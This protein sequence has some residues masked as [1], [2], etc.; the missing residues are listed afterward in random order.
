MMARAVAGIDFPL[1]SDGLTCYHVEIRG[2]LQ[3]SRRIAILLATFLVKVTGVQACK[4]TL[5]AFFQERIRLMSLI[6]TSIQ[7]KQAAIV[8]RLP[9]LVLLLICALG[10]ESGFLVNQFRP[11]EPPY[12]FLFFYLLGFIPYL[13]AC[14]L[15]LRTQAS[16]GRM[17][18]L[19]LGVILGGGLVLRWVLLGVEPILS[20]DSWRYLWDARVTLH[21]YSPYVYAPENPVLAFLRDAPYYKMGFHHVPTVYP[22][23][24]QAM[25]LLAYL[26]APANLVV[27]KAI[28]VLFD[29]ITCLVLVALLRRRGQD[30]RRVLIYAWCPLPILEFAVQGHV[31]ALAITL[32][33]LAILC[34][35]ASWRGSQVMTGAL[36]GLAT[37]AKFY[38]LLFLVV[39]LR[40]RDW[41]LLLSYLTVI[42]LGYLPYVILGHGQVFGFLSIYVDQHSPNSG[43]MQ[44]IMSWIYHRTGF[45][46]VTLEHGIEAILLGAVTFYILRL[47]LKERI[48]KEAALLIL[49]GS[50]FA[51][52]SHIFPWYTTALLPWIVLLIQPVWTNQEGLRP[53]G[54]AIA[55][56]WYFCGAIL[57]HYFFDR[58]SDWT[59]YYLIVYG[60]VMVGIGI[61]A[62][63]ARRWRKLQEAYNG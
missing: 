21:G 47:R 49:T 15:I 4:Q 17:G 11:G 13:L 34:S 2:F 37:L 43:L 27:L 20:P 59:L 16:K 52:S 30:M 51:V 61:A 41:A 10:V 29:L 12:L 24:A 26:I 18:W 25:Y 3:Q 8:W 38:P 62:Y 31:D 60:V 58:L 7:Q 48:S 14:M 42:L 53:V 54:L 32:T 5:S 9:V 56:T 57:L 39:V 19:E 1:S 36:L 45:Y 44:Q 22:P 23:F 28:F 6:E 46:N 35:E 63:Q 55:L 40:R 50:L 33:V